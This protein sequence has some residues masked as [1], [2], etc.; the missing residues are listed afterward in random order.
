MECDRGPG[1]PKGEP[2]SKSKPNQAEQPLYDGR[3]KTPER[4]PLPSV[5]DE[6]ER[7]ARLHE[8]LSSDRITWKDYEREE[9]KLNK[10]SNEMLDKRTPREKLILHLHTVISLQ[11]SGTLP[12]PAYI[13]TL[14]LEEFQ[15]FRSKV[16]LM[17]EEEVREEIRKAE[18]E[19]DRK[20]DEITRKKGGGGK[21]PPL[22]LALP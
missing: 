13:R 14:S 9:I 3:I 16:E 2:K 1:H 15:Q 6:L 4:Q 22:T 8:E 5:W 7:R 18:E 17:S 19:Y 11:P 12:L 21:P 10:L 20:D